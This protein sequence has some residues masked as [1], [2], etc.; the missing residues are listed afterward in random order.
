ML[1]PRARAPASGA[2]HGA[3]APQGLHG[4]YRAYMPHQFVWVPFNGFF[5]TFLGQ[6]DALDPTPPAEA[7]AAAG[8]A[9]STSA[10]LRGVLHTLVAAAM[11]SVVTNPIDV[12]KTRL[13]VAG[14]NPAVLSYSGPLDCLMQLLRHEGASAL[15]AGLVGRTLYVGPNFALFLPTY[16]LL[17]R[18]YGSD[19]A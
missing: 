6:L 8:G 1:P 7:S 5:F 16:D 15:F 11:A 14:A 18:L 3:R 2:Q 9:P 12:I 13:Q 10:Y 19:A 4:F 17:K